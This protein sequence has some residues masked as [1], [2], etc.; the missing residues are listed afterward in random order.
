MRRAI[1]D[2][3]RVQ[4]TING[5]KKVYQDKGYLDATVTFKS[6]P[7]PDNQ[8]IAVF[9]VNEGPLVRITAIDFI[10]NHAFTARQL[11]GVIETG[12]HNFLSFITGSG[13]LDRKKLERRR[14]TTS[15]PFT[16]T[17]AILTCGSASRRST[18][19]ARVSR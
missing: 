5:L 15:P 10:G 12:T 17:R 6:I 1:L 19:R 14:T 8:A 18:A 16:T 7:R 9:N 3:E 13:T 4:E 2:P 11:R